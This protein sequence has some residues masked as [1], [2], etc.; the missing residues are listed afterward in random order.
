VG[1]GH[2][3]RSM[4]GKDILEANNLGDG[5]NGGNENYYIRL[6]RI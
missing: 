5:E 6:D 1:W 2:L 4:Q 3:I